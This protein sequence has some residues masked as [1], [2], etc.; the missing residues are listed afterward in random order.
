[1]SRTS[2]VQGTFKARTLD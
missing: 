1:M 2:V